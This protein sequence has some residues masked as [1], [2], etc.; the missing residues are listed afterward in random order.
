MRWARRQASKLHTMAEYRPRK[1]A[2]VAPVPVF[3]AHGG[4]RARNLSLVESLKALGHEVHFVLL[5]SRQLGAFDE[6][7]HL[8][9]FGDRFHVFR[10]TPLLNALYLLRRA[11]FRMIRRVRSPFGAPFRLSHV[12]EIHYDGFT[13]Q[14]RKLVAQQLFDIVIVSYVTHSKILTACPSSVL[15]VIDTHDS[16]AGVLAPAQERK[17]LTRADVVLAIQEDEAREFRN[18]LGP[19]SSRVRVLSHITPAGPKLEAQANSKATFIGSS[20]AANL[21]AI[22]YFVDEVLPIIVLKDP[23][24]ELIVAGAISDDIPDKPNVRKLGRVDQVA[25]AFC[26]GPILVNP[27]RSGTGVKI[28]LLDAM[29][30]GVPA[31]STTLGVQGVDPAYLGGVIVVPDNDPVAF[32]NAVLRLTSLPEARHRLAEDA[33]LAARRWNAR[34]LQVLETLTIL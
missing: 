2:L 26:L 6:E 18:L 34:Q 8:R 5:P 7:A 16:Y 1:I 10:R 17:G 25:D 23:G 27:I 19:N 15:R 20:F 28:K 13:G 29:A 14:M 31:V 33:R 12:D 11:T 24:F 30:L 21:E 9:F 22:R 3:P 32:A 4:N